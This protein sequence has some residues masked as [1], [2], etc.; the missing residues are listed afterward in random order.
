MS[1]EHVPNYEERRDSIRAKRIV[2]VKHRRVKHKGK[3]VNGKWQVSLTE[4]MSL[5]GLLFV[6]P[7]G[8]DKG[9]VIEIEVVMSGILDIF[10][11]FG[12]VIRSSS[13]KGGHYYIAVRYVDLKPK[14]KT[15]SAK[16][17]IKRS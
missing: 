16:S 9:D 12:E 11:G 14:T 8:Y 17:V 1:L 3:S 15:R 10:K 2:T 6:S 7:V 4:N 5:S 13:Q